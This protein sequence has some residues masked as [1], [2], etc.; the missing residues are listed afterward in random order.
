MLDIIFI[1]CYINLS[2]RVPSALFFADLLKIRATKSCRLQL[3]AEAVSRWSSPIYINFRFMLCCWISLF[4]DVVPEQQERLAITAFL[5]RFLCNIY[6]PR[7][8]T[9][10][11]WA[12][13]IWRNLFP[14]PPVVRWQ[15]SSALIMWETN[16]NRPEVHLSLKCVY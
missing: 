2:L 14:R 1:E 6:F 10:G 8:G 4:Q 13:A 12:L 9:T 15:H 5:C 7:N 16:I 11:F 3:R